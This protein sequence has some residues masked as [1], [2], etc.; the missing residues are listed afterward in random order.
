MKVK[1]LA[2]VLEQAGWSYRST[3]GDHHTYKKP[4]ERY[5]ITVPG[6][7]SDDVSPGVLS[8]IRRKTGLP[9]R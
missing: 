7:P 8:A 1:D 3:T 2:A 9:L 5:V 6:K 4:G